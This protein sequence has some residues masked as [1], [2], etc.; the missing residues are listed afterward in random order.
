MDYD[1]FTNSKKI[2]WFDTGPWYNKNICSNYME[3]IMKILLHRLEQ[4]DTI[5]CV[6]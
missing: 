6:I 4:T 5:S 1:N 2:E 3:L